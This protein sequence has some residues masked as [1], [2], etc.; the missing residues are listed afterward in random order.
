MTCFYKQQSRSRRKADACQ[1]IMNFMW[2]H[3]PK[4]ADIPID[5]VINVLDGDMDKVDFLNQ[6]IVRTRIAFAHVT[7]LPPRYGTI[8][9]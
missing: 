2:I 4:T 7:V 8:L 1:F 6:K 3:T 5:G 9:A